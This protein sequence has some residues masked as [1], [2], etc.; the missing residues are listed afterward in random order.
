MANGRYTSA[1]EVDHKINK[2]SGGTDDDS[3]LQAIC[4]TCHEVKTEHESRHGRGGKKS[5]SN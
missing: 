4:K 5:T 1:S 2:A 3:N